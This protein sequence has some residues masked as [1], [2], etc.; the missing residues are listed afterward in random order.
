M[1]TLRLAAIVVLFFVG[2]SLRHWKVLDA[3]HG[4]RLLTIVVW[5]GLPTLILAGV[6]RLP[7]H[8][9]L[10][11]LPVSAAVTILV[12]CTLAAVVGRRLALEPQAYGAFVCC[13]T[14]L[15]ISLVYPFIL[16]ARGSDGFAEVAL[17]DL[18]NATMLCTF[19]YL[20]AARLGRR[21]N[22]WWQAVQRLGS[23]PPLWALTLALII[24][25]FAL[26]VSSVALDT[27][28]S[29]GG[30]VVLLVPVALGVLFDGRR[31]LSRPA[32]AAV[33]IHLAVGITMAL[34]CTLLL[35][36]HGLTRTV[37][38]VGCTAPIGFT[39]VVLA[40]RES[41]DVELAAS[42]TSLSVLL[43][44]LYIPLALLWLS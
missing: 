36:L 33:G 22:S 30:W 1:Q 16:A 25:L 35:G 28:Q 6:S 2:L 29:I 17:F 18:G 5:I 40:Q 39:V 32:L 15:N 3:G 43:G 44:L 20:L 14:A 10:V 4:K 13:F 9:Q 27:L 21:A 19:G 41:L 7:L 31:A 24:N 11:W 34:V 8:A 37:A 12:G 38:I 23:F 26:P 42:A